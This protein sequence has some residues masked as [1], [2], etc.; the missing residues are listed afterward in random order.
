VNVLRP[1]VAPRPLRLPGMPLT[2]CAY[3]A[4]TTMNPQFRA[5]ELPALDRFYLS[6]AM[7]GLVDEPPLGTR[8]FVEDDNRGAVTPEPVARLDGLDFHLSVKGIGSAVD[9]FGDR[10]LDRASAVGLTDDPEVRRRLGAPTFPSV[11]GEVDRLLTGELWLRGSPYGGQGLAHATLAL[12]VAQRADLT[13]I[14]GFRIAPLVKI[15]HLPPELEARVR[16]LH[17]YRRY[18]GPMAQE[19]RLVPSNVRLYFH[20]RTT[21]GHDIGRVFDLFGLDRSDKA[22]RFEVA[23]VRTA[24]AMLTLFARTLRRD[25]ATGRYRGLDFHDVWLDKDAVLAPDGS[26]FF[27]D[28][29][30][31]E[32]VGVERREVAEKI[33]DQ[34]FRSLYEFMFAY[35][36]I[37]EERARRFGA[38]GAR[39]A[40]FET[41][42]VEATREDPF[43]RARTGPSGTELEVR[44]PLGEG[45]L[46]T[47]FPL[48]DR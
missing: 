14:A 15:A 44:N 38:R 7:S 16:T 2:L 46:Y 45:D 41:L 29:E 36:Q 11:P 34:I 22:V 37:D 3:P 42:V 9:P 20:A 8:S 43:V 48:V 13:S 47:R 31:I 24:I 28:L 27:V 32:E 1:E 39:K 30:G 25:G 5:W 6:P 12:E 21:V 26:V 17:W 23:F 19:I 40:H 35:E 4:R 10:P 18:A 33:E